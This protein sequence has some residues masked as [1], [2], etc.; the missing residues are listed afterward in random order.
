MVVNH[1]EDKRQVKNYLRAMLITCT[2]VSFIG[3]AQIPGGGRVTAP[4]EGASGEPNTL[5][6]YLVFMI[7]ITMGL[8]LAT[9]MSKKN[10]VY[11]MLILLFA[12]P[13]FYTQ[14][15]SSYISMFFAV[16]TFLFLSEKRKWVFMILVLMGLALPFMTPE[17]A[18]ERLSYTFLQGKGR[19]DVVEIGGVKLD[20]STSARLLSW[21][22]AAVD[23]VKHPFIG[24]GITGYRFVDAQY[25]RLITE[26]GLLGLIT[27]FFLMVTLFKRAHSIF[28]SAD[29][30][31]EKGLSMGFLAGFIGLMVH[32]LGAN[33]FIIVRI[34]EPFWFIT[35]MVMLI[36]EL[37]DKKV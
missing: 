23:W 28:A 1:I 27:F 37:R 3:I 36:P 25:F 5:G 18:R 16:I 21:K 9:P 24:Y 26:T 12:I 11:G 15:R 7:S 20:T 8:L 17:V 19:A 32:G 33:T 22:N 4:F 6:G 10:L 14:S 29:D 13:L 30:V 35:A 34:M 2:I 31:F